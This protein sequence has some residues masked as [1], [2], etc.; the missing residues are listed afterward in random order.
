MRG[1]GGAGPACGMCVEM[2]AQATRRGRAMTMT[3]NDNGHDQDGNDD[4]NDNDNIMECNSN[5]NLQ[6]APATGRAALQATHCSD[7]A[8]SSARL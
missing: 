5:Y 2:M 7:V 8:H 6:L 1:A 3:T 4:D